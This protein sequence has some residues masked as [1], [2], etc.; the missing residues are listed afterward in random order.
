VC[1]SV[2]IFQFKTIKERSV[3]QKVLVRFGFIV[4]CVLLFP[5]FAKGQFQQSYKIGVGGSI[6]IQNVSGD[7]KVMG[8]DGS[9]VTVTGTKKGRNPE[10]V[11]IVDRSSEGRVDVGVEYPDCHN[12]CN[13]S[14]D[15]EVRVPRSIN[16]NFDKLS[17]ASG[18]IEVESVQGNLKASTASGDVTIKNASGSIKA[19]S[20]SGEVRVTD[21]AGEVNASTASGDVEVTITRLEGTG[22]MS[23][24]SASGDV[25]VRMPSNLDADVSLSTVS[26]NVKTDFPI[27]VEKDR[28]GAGSRAKGK[29][30]NGTRMVRLSSASGDVSLMRQ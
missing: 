6:K 10:R 5:Y 22:N 21:V 13:A 27:E 19:N 29:L 8:Y 14:V 12:G 24:S 3:M 4:F 26:G 18:D 11:E 9:T 20:A 17:T 25:N 15:F 30:G 1:F 2:I 16:F 28:W 7:I 23:F